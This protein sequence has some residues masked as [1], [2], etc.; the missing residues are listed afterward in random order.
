MKENIARG[1]AR[2]GDA[3]PSLRCIGAASFQLLRYTVFYLNINGN[4][5]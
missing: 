5:T 4:E 3:L 1:S 2:S